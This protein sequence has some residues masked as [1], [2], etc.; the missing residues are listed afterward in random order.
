MVLIF[1]RKS[2]SI[3][4]AGEL[5]SVWGKSQFPLQYTDRELT[6]HSS[7]HRD[8]KWAK[9]VKASG[10]AAWDQDALDGVNEMAR[11]NEELRRRVEGKNVLD[12][13]EEGS[14]VPSEEE[15]SDDDDDQSDNGA[16]QQSLGRLRTN[17]FSTDKSKLG[18]MAFMQRAEKAKRAQ[19]DEAVES[20]RRELAGED[21]ADD[22]VNENA[23]KAGRRKYGP[24]ANVA[25]PAIQINR[26][27]FEEH[28]GSDE[29]DGANGAGDDKGEPATDEPSQEAPKSTKRATNG[30]SN[31][32]RKDHRS[33]A[34]ATENEADA[35]NPFL[36]RAKK[37]KKPAP[38]P[39]LFPATEITKPSVQEK[40]IA[41]KP[42]PT[43]KSKAPKKSKS[44]EM[45]QEAK[46]DAFLEQRITAA[47]D[48]G[49]A[50]VLGGQ[51]ADED[52]DE[53]AI[54]DQGIDLTSVLRNNT[55]TAQGF[56]G[57]NVTADFLAEKSA[58]I[59]DE[60]STITTS[61]LPGWGSWTGSGMSK[62][63]AKRNTGLKTITKKEGIA[64]NK[65]KDRKLDKVIINEARAKPTVKYM[66]S[67][68]PFPFE[69]KEQYERSL[70]VP[71]GRE[72]VTKKTHQEGTRPRVIVK[73]GIV[74]PL[75][76]PLV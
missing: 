11:R 61:I 48:D 31:S 8:S 60:A 4:T 74:R 29:E 5:R 43:P 68:L 57:D 67:Q 1:L 21:S 63:E 59:A 51:D 76:K 42:K 56:A 30:L 18:Q 26:N 27:E 35:T 47:D 10:R 75:R 36:I 14:D 37:D 66:A 49:W 39:E 16:L 58:T 15:E 20:L 72:W 32:S 64:A 38:E 7:K 24:N 44:A 3:T 28:P 54:E 17:P 71:K 41:T 52:A 34:P 55:L 73:Q 70:R 22:E 46:V 62:S 45:P 2:A 19:N 25:A 23:A 13:D 69:S 12:D 40:S 65:R 6:Y 33:A 50:T 53:Q 9:G